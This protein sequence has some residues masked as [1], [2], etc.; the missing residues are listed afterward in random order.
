MS[1][2]EVQR[3]EYDRLVR[4][5]AQLVRERDQLLA[6]DLRK[7]AA[8]FS[9]NVANVVGQFAQRQDSATTARLARMVGAGRALYR[10]LDHRGGE[11]FLSDPG[12][13]AVLRRLSCEI[14]ERVNMA[15]HVLRYVALRR[16]LEAPCA[17]P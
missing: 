7:R 13:C 14:R 8:D 2:G 9:W 12:E 6:A 17:T 3:L 16:A 1:W 10:R 15:H 5:R 4:E 11:L